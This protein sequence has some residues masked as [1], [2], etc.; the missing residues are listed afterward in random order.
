MT[1]EKESNETHTQINETVKINERESN[2]R[3]NQS[4]ETHRDT[5]GREK[6]RQKK[7]SQMR[8]TQRLVT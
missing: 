4:N 6:W 8:H 2:D 5:N 3:E 7:K 1:E